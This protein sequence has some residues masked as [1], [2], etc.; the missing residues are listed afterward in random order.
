MEMKEKTSTLLMNLY[1]TKGL[2]ELIRQTNSL[3]V[4][5]EHGTEYHDEKSL[6]KGE[7]AEIVLYC[8]LLEF[9]KV[10]KFK[11]YVSK[12]LYVQDEH[13]GKVTE[14]DL[15]LITPY[16]IFIFESKS[17]SGKGKELRGICQLYRGD[18]MCA[19][20]YEQNKLHTLLFNQNY[21]MFTKQ[22]EKPYTM[23]LFDYATNLF[24]DKRE[25]RYRANFPVATKETVIKTIL[26]QVKKHPS[27]KVDV[28][29]MVQRIQEDRA[30]KKYLADEHRRQL[31]Y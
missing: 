6:I 31:G 16:K 11:T 29:R 2:A 23:V 7:I 30:T 21:G 13:S 10:A 26:D 19:D 24:V 1:K 12:G 20:V 15:V 28:D 4:Q 25:E 5:S 9:Q 8:I 22:S 3:I 14:L 18:K 27:K 17:Y